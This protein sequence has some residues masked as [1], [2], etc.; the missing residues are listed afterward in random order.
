MPIS[1]ETCKKYFDEFKSVSL[2][3]ESMAVKSVVCAEQVRV[4]AHALG[5]FREEL[6]ELVKE[7][8]IANKV[9]YSEAVTHAKDLIATEKFKD[10][11]SLQN[12]DLSENWWK[13]IRARFEERRDF[14]LLRERTV[15]IDCPNLAESDEILK[16][17]LQPE[18]SDTG[19]ANE[20][21]MTDHQ[22]YEIYLY[23]KHNPNKKYR[24]LVLRFVNKFLVGI[25]A[26]NIYN[27]IV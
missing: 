2:E 11:K 3:L 14:A 27:L 10:V 12:L 6:F 1:E 7:G 25:E 8:L 22:K 4:D 23:R 21:N 20:S 16:C 15:Q 24:D 19:E 26:E 5:E 18:N 9:T 13:K 17:D